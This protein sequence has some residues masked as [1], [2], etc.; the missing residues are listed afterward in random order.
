MVPHFSPKRILDIYANFLHYH[1]M[2]KSTLRIAVLVDTASGWGRRIIRGIAN[3][4][5]KHGPWQL[6]VD[7]RGIDESMDSGSKLR[8]YQIFTLGSP[9]GIYI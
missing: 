9:A 2:P 8:R 6:V 3:Y 7:E 5:V 4:G 1:V